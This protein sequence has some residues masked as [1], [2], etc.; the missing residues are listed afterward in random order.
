MMIKN[1]QINLI[2]LKKNSLESYTN[3]FINFI[4][5]NY[6]ESYKNLKD[7]INFSE[8]E[9]DD[10]WFKKI[11]EG[12]KNNK[13]LDILKRFRNIESSSFSFSKFANLIYEKTE[14][15]INSIKSYF[16]DSIKSEILSDLNSISSN[17]ENEEDIFIN[18]SDINDAK[19]NLINKLY[20]LFKNKIESNNIINFAPL[21]ENEIKK[22]IQSIKIIF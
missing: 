15:T 22:K 8:L 1:Y 16:P 21:D 7:E 13:S 18:D 14:E 2:I 9:P 19:Y 3:Y 4:E 10:D 17:L 20:K 12:M 6:P 5:K 11:Y